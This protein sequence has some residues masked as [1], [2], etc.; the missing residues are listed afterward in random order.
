MADPSKCTTPHKKKHPNQEQ[1][2]NAMRR[3]WRK[4]GAGARPIRVY[5]CACGWW[6]VT[7]KPLRV[8]THR[9]DKQAA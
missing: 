3:Y 1:A 7:K 2:E 5:Q 8:Y 6:H 9:Q 4:P